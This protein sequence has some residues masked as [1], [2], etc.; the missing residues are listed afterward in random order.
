VFATAMADAKDVY[1]ACATIFQMADSMSL[2]GY[3][4]GCFEG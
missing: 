2:F 1:I 4:D 3:C